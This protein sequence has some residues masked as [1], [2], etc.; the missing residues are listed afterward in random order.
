MHR[1]ASV[2][3]KFLSNLKK[4]NTVHI[5]ELGLAFTDKDSSWLREPSA[6]GCWRACTHSPF[7]VREQPTFKGGAWREGELLEFK[8]AGS[9][10]S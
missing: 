9:F 6:G 3:Q 7:K 8:D 5:P 10:P 1:L 4:N 2:S